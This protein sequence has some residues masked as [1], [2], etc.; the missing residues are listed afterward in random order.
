MNAARLLQFARDFIAE[1]NHFK[2]LA[3]I[4]EV[5]QLCSTRPQTTTPQ[6]YSASNNLR[7]QASEIIQKTRFSVYPYR[8]IETVE[9]T[10]YLNFL[11]ARVAAVILAGLTGDVTTTMSANECNAFL[12]SANS[13]Y[14]E[15]SLL[16]ATLQKLGVEPIVLVDDQISVE[17]SLPRISFDN[18]AH[19]YLDW[20][21][22]V[23]SIIT[24]YNEYIGTEDQR[25]R[26]VFTSTTDP[27]VGFTAYIH[28][29]YGVIQ[30]VNGLL[31]VAKNAIQLYSA[32]KQLREGKI[33]QNAAQFE[34]SVQD[35]V[36]K[37]VRKV[38]EETLK[39]LNTSLEEGRSNEIKNRITLNAVL[40][41]P[42]IIDGASIS[43][44]PESLNKISGTRADLI[45][46]GHP[47]FLV[48]L[49][50]TRTKE[51]EVRSAVLLNGGQNLMRIT[52]NKIE[53]E[54]NDKEGSS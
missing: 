40:L 49:A 35:L 37:E 17:F 15:L 34:K 50:D 44:S 27:V 10:S 51:E 12:S 2:I 11:P 54:P 9:K 28:A 3:V 30:L 31:S 22:K 38:V 33:A 45:V 18:I 21:D 48:L 7:A 47:T 39:P 20:N 42:I 6:F 13:A 32:I 53:D 29:A 43:I 23:I 5:S 16:A 4:G 19:D 36:E 14:N 1:Y 26:L 24:S 41:V 8:Y 52:Q 46:D 25:P